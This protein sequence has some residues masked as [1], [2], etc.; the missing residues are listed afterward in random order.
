[1]NTLGL[2]WWIEVKT[3]DPSYTYYFGPFAAQDEAEAAKS[4]YVQDLQQEGAQNIQAAVKRIKPEQ[5]TVEGSH[6]RDDQ[7]TTVTTQV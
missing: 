7:E 3:E 6:L 5:L 1:M 4:G 2:A